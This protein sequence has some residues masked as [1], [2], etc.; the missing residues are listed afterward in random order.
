MS[1][2]S[3]SSSERRSFLTYLNG[4]IASLVALA[5]G[6]SAMAQEKARAA[7]LEKARWEPA[8]H[9]KDD[10]L[11]E[12]PGKHRLIFDTS[13]P[14]GVGD[15][16]LFA[17]NFLRVNRTDYGLQDS[18][19]AVIIV[20]RHRSTPFG[21]KDAMWAKYGSALAEHA[22]PF[23][24]PKTKTTPRVN[25]YNS[26]D[27]GSLL[28]SRGTTLESLCKRGVQL[29]VCSSATR[30][31]AGAAAKESGGNIDAIYAELTANLLTNGR[32]VPAGIVAVSRAQERG[33]SLVKT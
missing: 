8:R 21:Y 9:D 2:Q 3:P 30:A 5:A 20:V 11:D 12:L 13:T 23:E 16:I 15:A 7:A 17:G 19:L 14:E 25:V 33:Y 27:Y 26:G 32:M 6:S 22:A 18:D 10:W 24:D 1:R 29:A 4:G 28:S 31:T